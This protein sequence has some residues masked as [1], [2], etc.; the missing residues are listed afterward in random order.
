[1]DKQT[2]A[3]QVL[4]IARQ[5]VE[6]LRDEGKKPHFVKHAD[7]VIGDARAA[8]RKFGPAA[9]IQEED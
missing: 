8:L 1:M 4:D 9:L 2:L 5:A 6:Y 3:E 7:D